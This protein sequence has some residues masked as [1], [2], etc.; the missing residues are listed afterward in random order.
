MIFDK[1]YRSRGLTGHLVGMCEAC[2]APILILIITMFYKKDEQ[3]RRISWFYVMASVVRTTPN[4]VDSNIVQN[5]ITMIFGGFVAYV[6]GAQQSTDSH[7][8]TIT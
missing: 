1:Y 4:V 3:A 5:G 6:S 8:L 2:V 7:N